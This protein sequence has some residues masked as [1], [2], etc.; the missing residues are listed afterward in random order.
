MRI[1]SIETQQRQ[2]SPRPPTSLLKLNSVASWRENLRKRKSSL[3]DLLFSPIWAKLT[4]SIMILLS[5]S[6][7]TFLKRRTTFAQGIIFI[8][9]A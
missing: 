9:A 1:E 3:T 2:R 5:L 6:H 8:R 4:F 7:L